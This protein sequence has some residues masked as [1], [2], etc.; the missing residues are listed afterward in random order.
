MSVTTADISYLRRL[1]VTFTD[2]Q[3]W[4]VSFCPQRGLHAS[5]GDF[6]LSW[7]SEAKE[8]AERWPEEIRE[9]LRGPKKSMR[10]MLMSCVLWL[11]D[12]VRL[13][14]DRCEGSLKSRWESRAPEYTNNGYVTILVCKHCGGQMIKDHMCRSCG[15]PWEAEERKAG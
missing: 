2:R 12:Q 3:D 1:L 14:C 8:A 15:A 10:A 6:S 7:Q 4:S 5:C 9:R 11:V 13:F